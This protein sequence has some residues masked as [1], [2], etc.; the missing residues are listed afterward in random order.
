VK[1]S[2]IVPVALNTTLPSDKLNM[3]P[4]EGT[5]ETVQLAFDPVV[6]TPKLYS[7]SVVAELVKVLVSVDVPLSTFIIFVV[8]AAG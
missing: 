1:L 7:V 4:V 3:A 2:V 6:V 5:A 8:V